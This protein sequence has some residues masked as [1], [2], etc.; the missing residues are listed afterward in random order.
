MIRSSHCCV[1]LDHN[2]AK[3]LCD[4]HIVQ[5]NINASLQFASRLN[6]AHTDAPVQRNATM[7]VRR[8]QAFEPFMASSLGPLCTPNRSVLR[9]SRSSATTSFRPLRSRNICP[10]QA[11]PRAARCGTVASPSAPAGL[12]QTNRA[13]PGYDTNCR[14]ICH[15]S[16]F[17][18]RLRHAVPP[19]TSGGAMANPHGLRSHHAAAGSS[20]WSGR[21]RSTQGDGTDSGVRPTRRRCPD[22]SGMCNMTRQAGRWIPS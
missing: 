13:Q 11:G 2:V 15:S 20:G 10:M 6:S 7:P 14:Y 16:G 4:F 9:Q 21:R 12:R 18:P 8:S 22:V 5:R 17:T 3:I 19:A 1:A